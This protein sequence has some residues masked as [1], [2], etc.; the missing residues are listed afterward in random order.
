[1]PA[2]NDTTA[3]KRLREWWAY[4]PRRG[5]QRLISPWEYRHLRVFGI[6]RIVGGAVAVLA[7]VICLPYAAYGWAAFFLVLGGL[8]LAGGCWY[9]AIA[10]SPRPGA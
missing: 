2:A 5:I 10:R 8:N 3:R 6:T 1:M 9:T 7:G 4:P